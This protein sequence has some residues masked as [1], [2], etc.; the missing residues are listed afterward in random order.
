MNNISKCRNNAFG[1]KGAAKKMLTI[2][3]ILFAVIAHAQDDV[4][5][6]PT[7]TGTIFIT[8]A[9]IHT[10]TGNVIEKGTIKFTNGKIEAVG[11]DIVAPPSAMVINAVGKHVYPGLILTNSNLGLVEINSVR[12]TSD[13]REIGNMNA[14]VRSIVAY[15]TASKI[16]NVLRSNGILLANIVPQG[17]FLTGQ[18]SVVQL[19]A[20]TWQDAGY[21]TDIGLSLNMPA[22]IARP[23][24]GGGGG[25]FRRGLGGAEG[26]DPVKAGLEQIESLKTYFREAKA[27]YADANHDATNLK[28]EALQGLF[29]KTKKLFINANTAKQILVALDF[30]TEFGFDIVIVGGSESYQVADLL[31]KHNVPVILDQPHNL[32]TREDDDVDLPYKRASLL[33]KAGVLFAINDDDPQTRGR[34]LSYNAGTCAT[35]GLTKEEALQAITLNAAKIL[36]IDNITGSIEVGKDANI[37]ISTGDILDMRTSQVTSAFIQGRQIN[38][39]SKQTQL[40]ERYKAKYGIQ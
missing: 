13:A 22:L 28:Y 26:T 12:A 30:I 14:S 21:K 27:Y 9:T 15:N 20:W 5:P 7:Q 19:D 10:G 37:V 36:G 6:S 18:N 25:G 3:S 32:P 33:Q 23:Q 39:A 40:N 16:I 8:N 35:Y 38:L 24:F 1:F 4:L 29:N 31:K 34:N 17:T 2:V 11:A